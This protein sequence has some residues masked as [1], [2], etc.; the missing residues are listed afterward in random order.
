MQSADL[1]LSARWVIPV[2]DAAPI[3]DHHSVII[4]DGR[5]LAIE[6]TATLTGRFEATEH[7]DLPNHALIPGLINTHTH[8][9]MTLFRG[10]ADDMPLMRWLNDYIWPAEGR[11]V[12]AA[13]VRDGSRHAI[14]EMIRGGI[15]CFNDMYFY[16]DVVAREA[17]SAGMR[18]AM[19]LIVIDF[20]TVWAQNA[21]EYISKGLECNDEFGSHPLV[22][23]VFAPHAPYTVSD[24]PLERIRTLS[25]ELDMPV[26]MH[27]HETAA[28]VSQAVEQTGERPLDRLERLGLLSPNLLAVHMTALNAE[29]IG[30]VAAAGVNVVHCPESNLK[31]ASGFCP[32][33]SLVDAGANIA[34]GTD[35]AASNNDLNLLGEARSAAL[36]AK[37]VAGDAAA[38]PAPAA[39]RAAT[40][41]GARAL[42]L[43]DETG[44]LEAGKSADITAIDLHG[45]ETQP[46]Y[47][48]VSQ[49]IY[50]AGR[51]QV[52]DVWV[53][54]RNLLRNRELVTLDTDAIVATASGWREKIAATDA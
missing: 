16:P 18:C 26:H 47:D 28:E 48:A 39:L 12:D 33:Q 31:L 41:G 11:W 42:G 38:F 15:T 52:S 1:I 45:L 46:V 34:L 37:A 14:A 19:G 44:S 8:A 10:F 54:G 25:D 24:K 7:R 51:H 50:A 23:G 13:F 21:D 53:A 49:I 35:G 32:V 6:P 3:L 30:R 43:G 4:R 29:E 40:L 22:R 36:L 20:P 2:T 17:I 5:I 9:A 27:V